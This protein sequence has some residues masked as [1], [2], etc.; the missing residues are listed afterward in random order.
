MNEDKREPGIYSNSDCVDVI[1]A[2][3]GVRPGGADKVDRVGIG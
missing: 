1:D 3:A 2:G